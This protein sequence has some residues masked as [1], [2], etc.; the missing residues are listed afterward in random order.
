V[1]TLAS[2]LADNARPVYERLAGYL[3]RRLGEP[4]GLSGAP[5][6]ER[7]QMLDEGRVD[8][9]FIC[10]LPYSE[11]VDRLELLCAPVMAHPRYAGRPAYFAD[12]IVRRDS[13]ARTFADLR[14]TVWA[15]NDP[16]SNSG[17]VM[18]RHHLLTLGETRGYFA[19]AVA[20]GSHQQSIRW[21]V[22]RTV[23]AAG[24]DS[25]VLELELARCPAL[26][27]DVRV[28]E[29][30]GPCPIPPVV[31]GRHLAAARTRRLREAFL[32]LHEDPEARPILAEG[33]IARFV[34]VT[35]A[36][37]DPIREMVRRAQAAGFLAL[38]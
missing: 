17:Y 9:A 31:V 6:D 34:P 11:R 30:I 29:S 26:A 38:R 21:V 16:A 15:Y 25:T 22:D 24:I 12:A 36:D 19:R 35:D 14:G 18:P 10:G 7:R 3:A 13:P 1:L 8:V 32:A 37:Y 23:D 27:H 33:G 5:W 4:A 2:F 20:S 28:V